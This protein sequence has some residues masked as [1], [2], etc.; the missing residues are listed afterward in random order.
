MRSV[1]ASG[2]GSENGARAAPLS[3]WTTRT[4]TRVHRRRPRSSKRSSTTALAA[5]A[6]RQPTPASE[7]KNHTPRAAIGINSGCR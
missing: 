7:K 1:V 2:S 3:N 5:K 6:T 4:K